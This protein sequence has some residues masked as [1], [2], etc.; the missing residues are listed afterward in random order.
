MVG[1]QICDQPPFARQA[2]EETEKN[3]ALRAMD[4]ESGDSFIVHGRGILH[5]Y[6]NRNYAS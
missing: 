4:S 6:I 2:D 1:W 5:W 3:L